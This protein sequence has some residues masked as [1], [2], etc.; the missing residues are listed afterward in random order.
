MTDVRG[1]PSPLA[2]FDCATCRVCGVASWVPNGTPDN[3]VVYCPDHFPTVLPMPP[4][5]E[6]ERLRVSTTYGKPVVKEPKR[7]PKP[8]PPPPRPAR[9]GYWQRRRTRKEQALARGALVAEAARTRTLNAERVLIEADGEAF[10][11]DFE[12]WDAEETE[13][14]RR[15]LLDHLKHFYPDASDESLERL[16]ARMR[17]RLRDET[18]KGDGP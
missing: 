7:G 8:P 14:I 9:E 3:A 17:T 1:I 10:V 5:R 6:A 16:V 12:R 13:R 15:R 4:S 2:L 18:A 11:R